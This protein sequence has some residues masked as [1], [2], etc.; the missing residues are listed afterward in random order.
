MAAICAEVGDAV[1]GIDACLGEAVGGEKAA[2]RED[3]SLV[4]TASVDAPTTPFP[5]ERLFGARISALYLFWKR[6]TASFVF[7][8]KYLV[9]WPLATP[10]M[11]VTGSESSIF[12]SSRTSDPDMPSLSVRGNETEAWTGTADDRAIQT[13]AM[14]KRAAAVDRRL[15]PEFYHICA[16][17]DFHNAYSGAIRLSPVQRC[18]LYM[19]TVLLRHAVADSLGRIKSGESRLG[20]RVGGHADD[21]A[22]SI[23]KGRAGQ[24][25]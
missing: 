16:H 24:K 18:Q 5:E 14:L 22:G 20:E 8:P 12:W 7:T 19:T 11:A 25:A 6:I 17:I 2:A 1:A 10:L 4:S 21:R 13:A 15:M 23:E 3:A 9:S